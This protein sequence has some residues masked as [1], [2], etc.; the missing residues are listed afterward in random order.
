MINKFSRP[1][2]I[3]L[4]LLLILCLI[5]PGCSRGIKE[6]LYAFTGSSGDAA[7]ISGSTEQIAQLTT[8]YGSCQIEPFTNQVGEIC[9]PEFLD[10]LP[11]KIEEELQYQSRSFSDTISGKDKEEAGPLFIGPNEKYIMITGAVIHYDIGD[12]TDKIISPL[13]EAICRVQLID[14][15]SGD[16][17]IEANITSRAKSSIRTGTNELAHGIAKGIK[18]L[19]QTEK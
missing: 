12:V 16:T 8:Q 7:L 11:T 4:S 9:P 19:L 13:D 15:I 14:P 3:T 2:R 1:L 6:G 17:L 10:L 5:T 18:K